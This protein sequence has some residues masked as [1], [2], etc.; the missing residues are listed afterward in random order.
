MTAFPSRATWALCGA[1]IAIADVAAPAGAAAQEQFD[2]A[3][4]L[5]TAVD[6]PTPKD[7]ERA[8]MQ[9]AQRE[10][11]TLEALL[12]AMR[13]FGPAGPLP[14]GD[15]DLRVT[16][17]VGEAREETAVAV[18]VPRGV[19]VGKPAPLL[20]AFH[21]AGGEGRGEDAIWREV[22]D[23]IGMI[24]VAPT[25]K[26]ADLGYQFTET[27]RRRALAALRW[28]RRHFDVDENRVYVA[29]VSR[30]GHLVWDLAL[31]HPDAFAAVVPMIGGPR[32]S[33]QGGQHNLRNLENVVPVALRDLQGML[34]DPL[35]VENLRLA[36]G[37]LRRMGAR[38]AR[39][40]EF[41]E[42]GHDFDPAGVPW[43]EFL[44]GAVR[45]PMPLRVVRA[46]ARLDEARSFWAEV[47][48]VDP[49]V[50]EKFVPRIEASRW[51]SLDDSARRG[52]LLEE[53]DRRTARLEVK[54]T[55]PGAF[56][57]EGTRVLRFRLLLDEAMLQPGKAVQVT[58]QGKTKG[59]AAKPSKL[60]LLREFVERFDRTFLPV[61]EVGVP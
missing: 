9:L 20:L 35:L 52:L 49:I 11:V 16:L 53:A 38:D 5:A 42:L 4:A 2:L 46:C 19:E 32:L 41:P 50:E 23:E 40:V 24:V 45:E 27:E 57:A 22:A 36:F 33:I 54:M 59:Y 6:L 60:L 15:H 48:R 21:G 51:E 10:D 18:H 58:W 14:A 44:E 29:G 61:G 47:T 37:R 8:A 55:A 12:A 26:T 39:M 17:A 31:R 28:A 3:R 7:R 34:D 56:V 43:K 30:G 25:D 1:A 13:R